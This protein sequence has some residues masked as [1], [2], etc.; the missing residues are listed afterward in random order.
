MKKKIFLFIVLF[1]IILTYP[2]AENIINY[3]WSFNKTNYNYGYGLNNV[4]IV[5]NKYLTWHIDKENFNNIVT[6]YSESGNVL[7]SF[8]PEIE[9][10]IVDIIYYDNNYIAI[11]KLGT[12][13]KLDKDFKIIR[14]ITNSEKNPI[15]N[16]KSELK[17]SQNTIYYID[18]INNNIFSTDYQLNNYKY[19]TLSNKNTIEQILTSIPFL[20]EADKIYFSYLENNEDVIITDIFENNSFYYITSYNK[21]NTDLKSS[22]KLVDENLNVIWEDTYNDL[23][24]INV[25]QF[26]DYIFVLS[27]SPENQ[28]YNIKV[29]NKEHHLINEEIIK[30]KDKNAIPI[31]F[32]ADDRNLLIKSIIY[33]AEKVL[34]LDIAENYSEIIID[35][36]NIKL[37]NIKSV[38]KGEGTI[39]VDEN[40]ITGDLVKFKIIAKN[41]YKLEKLSIKDI[42]GNSL[43]LSDY[44][45]KMPSSDVTITAIFVPENP[46]TSDNISN[47]ILL[48]SISLVIL[49]ISIYKHKRCKI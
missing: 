24:P 8:E 26:K 41:G 44:T 4:L 42:D 12:I 2:K 16:D 3:D 49:I 21:K 34:T 14:S 25:L 39:E 48:F 18:K 17:I 46:N 13:Y 9:N 33:K 36:Y 7:T 32:I 45:F 15:I 22:L 38:I 40:A 43:P 47:L 29:Y 11:D 35:K 30:L 5:N 31:S 10:P 1:F 20:N 28:N 27:T 23:I 6:L 37:F 19:Y